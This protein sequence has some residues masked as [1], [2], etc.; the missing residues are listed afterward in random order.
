VQWIASERAGQSVVPASFWVLSLA[1]SALLLAYALV[2]RDP[3]FVLA[4]LPN[5]L[6][7]LRNLALV[8]RRAAAAGLGAPR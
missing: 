1:G 8:R 6:V 5:G 4:N 3:V 2:R 7:Y